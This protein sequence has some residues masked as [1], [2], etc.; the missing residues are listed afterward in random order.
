MPD[1]AAPVGLIGPNA[2]TQLLPL[3][4]QAGG[5]ELRDALLLEAGIVTLPDMTG[6]I[7]EAPVARLHQ[8][9]R[10]EVPELAPA[11]AWAAGER[12]AQY[13]L[14]NRIPRGAQW[15]LKA[16]PGRIAGPI[17]ARAIAKNAWTFTGSGAFEILSLR[18]LRFAITDNPVVRGEFSAHPLCH[19]HTAVFEHLFRVLVDDRLRARETAC[20]AMGAE[21]CVFEIG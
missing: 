8:A 9:M 2:L 14:E 12:T 17:L 5:A 16:L 10:A 20:C 3:L 13:I 21:A 11:L 6:L 7:D 19:W 18:P 4:E 1:G 15:V